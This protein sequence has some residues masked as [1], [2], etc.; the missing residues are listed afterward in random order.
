MRELDERVP[1]AKPVHGVERGCFAAEDNDVVC[2]AFLLPS[3]ERNGVGPLARAEMMLNSYFV[4]YD[5]Y[6]R[7]V[8]NVLLLGFLKV[9]HL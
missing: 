9:V 2:V 8:V 6:Y 1:R 5:D 7:E 4:H 3:G